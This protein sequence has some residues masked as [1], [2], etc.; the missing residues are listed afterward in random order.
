MDPLS[1]FL[2]LAVG[3]F[4]G[5]LGGYL[6]TA[7]YNEH[8]QESRQESLRKD[9]ANLILKEQ[10]RRSVENWEERKSFFDFDCSVCNLAGEKSGE[11]NNLLS[12]SLC[13]R[14]LRDHPHLKP[15]LTEIAKKLFEELHQEPYI[16]EDTHKELLQDFDR[17][18][19]EEA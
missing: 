5:G 1:C 15:G 13:S 10:H 18:L 6:L 8:K 12:V 2:L 16:P 14:C 9:A 17:Q 19:A 3:L 7:T 4:G 11:R